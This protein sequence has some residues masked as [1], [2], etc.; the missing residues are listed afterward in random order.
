MTERYDFQNCFPRGHKSARLARQLNAALN[1]VGGNER[2]LD[3]RRNTLIYFCCY[4]RDAGTSLRNFRLVTEDIIEGYIRYRE[5][6]G[7]C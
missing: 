1:S 2:T 7:M 5:N 3:S 6:K 4:V